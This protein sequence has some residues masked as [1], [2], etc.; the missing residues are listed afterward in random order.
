MILSSRSSVIASAIIVALIFSAVGGYV[1]LTNQ[2]APSNIAVVML[3]PGR[4][5]MSM[6]DQVVEGLQELQGD[7]TVNYEYF[8]AVN[9]DGAQDIMENL[10]SQGTYDLIIVIGQEL[11]QKLQT[12]ASTHTNQ[13]FAFIGGT[14]IADNVISATFAQHEAAF[15]AGSLAAFISVQNVNCSGIVGILGSVE[16]DPTVISLVSGFTQGLEYANTTYALNVRLLEPEYVG[17]YND[18]DTASTLAYDMFEPN[19]GNATIIFAPVR[20]SIIGVR[21]AMELA[22]S[23]YY[24]NVTG[25]N[26]FVI[27]AEGN[28]DYLG[29][30]D[31]NIRSGER[32]W[33]VTSVVPRS[34]LAVYTII[35]ATLWDE[36]EGGVLSYNLMNGGVNVTDFELSQWWVTAPIRAQLEGIRL[37]IMNGTIT[38]DDGLP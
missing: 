4:G 6:V 19:G 20:A 16:S 27:A 28:Q 31:I 10:A 5:D 37:S 9:A 15:I 25:R 23:T 24:V 18:S 34:D 30:P 3:Q 2:Y 29:L 21:E 22:N 33:V 12:V 26:P 35:N 17:S 1:F 32:S 11:A 14:V 7:V 38:V 8:E 13:K 36:F